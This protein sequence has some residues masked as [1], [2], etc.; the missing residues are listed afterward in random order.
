[1]KKENVKIKIDPNK[2]KKRNEMHLES[3]IKYPMQV[4]ES[5]KKYNRKKLKK[6]DEEV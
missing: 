4:Q 6:T 1:M 5:K 3:Q 2:L